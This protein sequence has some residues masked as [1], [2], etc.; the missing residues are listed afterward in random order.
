VTAAKT[1]AIH[2]LAAGLD[3]LEPDRV[4]EILAEG[5]A[6]AAQVPGECREAIAAGARLVADALSAGN[7]VVYAGAG[8]SGLMAMTDA[9]ELPGTFGVPGG[10]IVMLLAGGS[11][12]FLD[13]AG[14][15]EDDTGLAERD[16]ADAGVSK[17]DCMIAISAS[18]STPYAIAAAD[19]ARSRG[20][21]VIAIANNPDA[22]L[23]EGADVSILLQTPPEVVA[24]ST[25][26]GA[27]TA[28]KIALNMMSTLVAIHLGHVHDGFMVNLRADNDKLRERAKRIVSG[29]AGVSSEI[30]EKH[31]ELAGGSIKSAVMLA[32]GVPDTAAA[33][34][35]LNRADQNLRR[36]LLLK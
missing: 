16:V 19:N 33:Q 4:L 14:G 31:L 27:G 3:A 13:L 5:Q 36:A 28:Q 32:T 17:G 25:R 26:M 10:R 30:A 20:A 2:A 29:I 6:E 22:L 7:R 21:R 1:E 23:F 24:G 11:S 34:E 12:S 8:S 18:G 35:I 15:Y 9:L